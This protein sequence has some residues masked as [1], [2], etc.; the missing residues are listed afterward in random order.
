MTSSTTSNG[1]G[2]TSEFSFISS[3]QYAFGRISECSDIICPSLIYVGPSSSRMTR[4][5]SGV[6]PRVIRFRCSTSRISR[7]R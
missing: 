2:V 4:S 3:S 6:T 5:F 7:K 1:I